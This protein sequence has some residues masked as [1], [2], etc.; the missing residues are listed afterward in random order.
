MPKISVIVPVYNTEKYIEKC[1]E[2][3][4]NQTMKD[5]EILVINDGST[6]Q[7]E[8]IIKKYKEEHK[9]INIRYFKKENGGLSDA[10]N[11]ALSYV[12]GKYISFVDSDDYIDSNLY[13][14]LEEYMEQEIDLIKFKIQMVNEEGK[15]LQK[16]EGPVFEKC[17]GEQAFEKLCIKEKFLD[18][19]CIYLYK[20]EFFM[21]NHFQ[22]RIG[23]YHEDFG[24]TPLIIVKAKSFVSVEEYG[25][26]Y[27]QTVNSITREINYEKEIKKAKDLLEHY[28]NM[29][30][31]IEK[32]EI[33]K[34]SKELVKRYYT[35]AILL[36][37]NDLKG[38]DLQ[39]YIKQIRQRKMYQNIKSYNLKQFIKRTLLRMSVKLYLKMR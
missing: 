32:Y 23:T 15:V 1:L 36:K 28:D 2:S 22:Y 31:T 14:H 24:L 30:K 29:I 9:D 4:A 20:T 18:P 37:A 21:K 6:D 34:K 7:S 16:Q 8:E 12:T 3:I 11:F 10:R 5:L 13:S 33:E 27:L 19:A 26:Y 25:Y 39:E 38:D 17:I 35:N